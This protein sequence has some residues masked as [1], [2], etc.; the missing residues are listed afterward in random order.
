MDSGSLSKM[1]FVLPERVCPFFN[2]PLLG[3]LKFAKLVLPTSQNI[4]PL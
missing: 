3:K 1:T 2:R 4:F